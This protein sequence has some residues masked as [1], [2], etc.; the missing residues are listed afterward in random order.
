MWALFMAWYLDQSRGGVHS[1]EIC[2]PGRGLGDR[3]AGAHRHHQEMGTETPF[4]I[5]RAIIST[6][7]RG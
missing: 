7:R 4:N 5:N 2:L 3:L 6:A 1:P